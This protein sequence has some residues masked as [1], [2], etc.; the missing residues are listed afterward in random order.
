MYAI[1]KLSGQEYVDEYAQRAKVSVPRPRRH[2]GTGDGAPADTASPD[3]RTGSA[4]SED[5]TTGDARPRHVEPRTGIA[6][7]SADEPA[8]D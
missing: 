2:R 8:D 7:V 6:A 1:M 3:G 4:G 5:G